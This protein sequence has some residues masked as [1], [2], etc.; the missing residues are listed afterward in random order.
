[1]SKSNAI[2]LLLVA[3]V[4]TLA[5]ATNYVRGGL[6]ADARKSRQLNLF[7]EDR[8]IGGSRAEKDRYPYTVSMQDGSHFCGGSLISRDCESARCKARRSQHRTERLS[9]HRRHSLSHLSNPIMT[10]VLTAAHCLGGSY[11]VRI[12]SDS[13]GSGERIEMQ[14]EYEHPNY[15]TRTDEFDIALIKLDRPTNLDV[16][17][18]RINDNNN[19]PATRTTVTV[20]GWG[21]TNP[22]DSR[23]EMAKNLMEVNLDVISNSQCE[24]SKKNNDS[25]NGFI[26]QSML[27][28]QTRNKDACQGDSGGPLVIKGN[29]PEEDIQVG[30]VSWGIGCAYLPGVFSRVS[31]AHG[32]IKK[33]VCAQSRDPPAELCDLVVETPRPTPRPTPNPTRLPTRP[34]TASP[35]EEPTVR[36]QCSSNTF[37]SKI[38]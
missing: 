33:T 30:V 21:D 10:V 4:I 37:C 23:Q 8:I 38:S 14:R 19:V 36:T 13:V 22:S 29:T 15:S 1:M 18:I 31:R 32:W 7:K 3:A 35:T 28:T 11:D 17:L 2:Q 9:R 5:A 20:M 16:P 25:Y 24:K 26:Y 27:C 34:P 6:D 12:G